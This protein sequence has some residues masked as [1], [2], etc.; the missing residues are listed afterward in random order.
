[1]N[2]QASQA[3]HWYTRDGAPMYEVEAKKGGMRATT[4]RDA[5][6][7]DLVPSVTLILSVAAKPGLEAWKAKQILE[8]SLTLPW[9]DGE[10]IDEYAVRVI[11]D[12]KAQSIKARDKGT[13]LHAAIER[14]IRGEDAYEWSE[15][16]GAIWTAADQYGLDLASGEAEH[17]FASTSFGYGGKIDFHRDDPPFVCDFKTKNDIQ[18]NK[19]LVW[20]EHVQQLAA[21]GFGL[22]PAQNFRAFNIFIGLEDRQVRVVEHEWPDLV[23][24]FAQFRCL[25]EYWQRIKRFGPH[26]K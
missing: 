5:V 3:G 15:H 25:L 24:A 2:E 17:S 1:M 26:A 7:L 13:A 14:S 19:Q 16:I 8:A 20:P 22:F 6:K 9:N 21:Y 23:E 10:S 11:E 4:I 18:D 12:S